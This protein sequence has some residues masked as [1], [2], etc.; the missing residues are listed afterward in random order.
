MPLTATAEHQG[1]LACRAVCFLLLWPV[2]L[3]NDSAGIPVQ[4]SAWA[5]LSDWSDFYWEPATTALFRNHI[6]TMTNRVNSVN[7]EAACL[8]AGCWLQLMHSF[9][10]SCQMRCMQTSLMLPWC[11]P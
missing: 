5:N 8:L 6:H 4:Y 10:Q 9:V 3:C 11:R 1:S 2:Q 7:G